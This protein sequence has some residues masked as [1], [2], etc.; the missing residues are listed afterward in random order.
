MGSRVE[1]ER[2]WQ[3]HVRSARQRYEEESSEFSRVTA[4][5]REGL[6]QASDGGTA[7]RLARRRESLALN[8]YMRALQIYTDLVL[9]GILPEEPPKSSEPS[10]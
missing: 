5:F 3:A 10:S 6:Y 9:K 2:V 1:L 8:E 7:L 4:D